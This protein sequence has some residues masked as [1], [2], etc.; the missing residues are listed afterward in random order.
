MDLNHFVR[1]DRIGWVDVVLVLS[2]FRA[3]L[4]AV[5]QAAVGMEAVDVNRS[6]LELS[7]TNAQALPWF[8]VRLLQLRPPDSRLRVNGLVT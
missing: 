1:A 5:E 6:V 8:Q 7:S 2:P 3:A 4:T